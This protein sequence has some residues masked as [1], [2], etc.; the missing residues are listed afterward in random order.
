M[1]REGKLPKDTDG[2]MEE[3]TELKPN[4]FKGVSLGTVLVSFPESRNVLQG[5]IFIGVTNE[6]FQLAAGTKTLTLA[7]PGP[8]STTPGNDFSP[9]QQKILVKAGE[10]KHVEFT[11]N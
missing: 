6:P 8:D 11:K 4:T 5:T 10:R 9:K 7:S 1:S 3:H 2:A